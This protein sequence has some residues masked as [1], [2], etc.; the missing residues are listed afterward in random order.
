MI[1]TPISKLFAKTA[2]FSDIK[3]N[4][5]IAT[6]FG[7]KFNGTIEDIL[8]NGDRVTLTIE[9]GRITQSARSGKANFK[10]LFFGANDKLHDLVYK[11]D[12][13]GNL[14]SRMRKIP[15]G[16]EFLNSENKL[17]KTTIQNPDKSAM[18]IKHPQD[19]SD[20]TS[21]VTFREGKPHQIISKSKYQGQEILADFEQ[22]KLNV[23]KGKYGAEM[24]G[25]TLQIKDKNHEY[26]Y[27]LSKRTLSVDDGTEQLIAQ[28][29]SHAYDSTSGYAKLRQHCIDFVPENM[30]KRFYQEVILPILNQNSE[31]KVS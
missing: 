30:G 18:V 27:H 8:K 29:S 22:G 26:L 11:Y 7:L 19:K 4:K 12:E 1:I 16:F 10:K 17:I 14:I 23:K 21:I 9:K 24:Q 20:L 2:K 15:N 25:D 13:N 3:F 31:N 5:G 28:H 6:R